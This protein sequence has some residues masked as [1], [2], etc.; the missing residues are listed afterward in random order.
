MTILTFDIED[1]FNTHQNRRH[2]SGQIWDDLPSKVIENTGRI[3]DLLEKHNKTATFF[4]LGWVAKKHPSLV[5]EIY[6]KGHEIGSHSYWHHNPHFITPDDFAKDTKLSLDVLQDITGEKIKAYRAPGFNLNLNDNW[7]F[8]ILAENGIII[9]SSV[10]LRKKPENIPVTINTSKHKILEF[11]LIKSIFGFPYSGG[12][13][14]R[15]M[16]ESWL[17]YF[18]KKDDY[19]LLYFHPRDFDPDMP[20]TNLFSFFRNSL[21]RYNTAE[22]IKRLDNILN[23]YDTITLFEA[24]NFIKG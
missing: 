13:Y 10:E 24:A 15:A 23:D 14:F 4:I 5:R 6:N 2:Y 1:W 19:H 8:E 9:D 12:G 17:N 20:S 3:L 18:F 16:P 7:A 21:N 11:P 22:C